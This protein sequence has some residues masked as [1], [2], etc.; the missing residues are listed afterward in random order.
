MK[1]RS[2][3]IIIRF[4]DV[5]HR[6]Y[7]PAAGPLQANR[8][9]IRL[10]PEESMQLVMMAKNLEKLDMELQPVTLNLNF[11]E[12][13]K[14]FRSDAYKRL[15]IDAAAGNPSLFIHRDEVRSAWAWI[16]PIISQWQQSGRAP[17]PYRAG[18]WGPESADAL[19]AE[20]GHAWFNIAED[21]H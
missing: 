11:N 21:D 19:L 17:E 1:K 16:D 7:A 13:Y 8:L 3:E 5:S 9:V 20:G 2:A 10:Q 18:S 4:K 15:I 6:V 12:T 14:K